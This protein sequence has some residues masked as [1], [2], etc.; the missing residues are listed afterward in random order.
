MRAICAEPP[1]SPI[2]TPTPQLPSCR[3]DPDYSAA[4]VILKTSVEGLEGHGLTF[5]IGRGNEVV[6]AAIK[7]LAHLVVG[8][9]LELFTSNMGRFWHHI[10]GDS[11]L[12]WIGPDK[13]AIHL[14]TGAVG[15]AVWDLWG[16]QLGKPVWKIV[17]D[18]TPEERVALIDFK[19]ID[20]AITPEEALAIFRAAEAG[21]EERIKEMA[22]TGYPAYITS[23][24]RWLRRLT[25][26]HTRARQQPSLIHHPL[27]R[28]HPHARR[29]GS[30]TRRSW[31]AS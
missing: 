8:F 1:H 17:A 9:D 21:K 7:A 10:T 30:N 6:G 22:E 28:L 2:P 15:N 23:T 13:G 25:F 31:C 11:R 20:D 5:T 14:A 27:P 26:H 18:M 19:Y 29:A 3:R 4:Y 16:K 12:R 24:V